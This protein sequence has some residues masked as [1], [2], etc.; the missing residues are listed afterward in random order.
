M[1]TV[2]I[3]NKSSHDYSKAEYFGKI[4]YLFVG[5]MCV[6]SVNDLDRQFQ[7]RLK[8]STDKDYLVLTSLTVMNSLACVILALKHKKLNLL[9]YK[10]GNY[11]ERNLHFKEL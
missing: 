4:I 9:I 6:Y 8:D 11:I 1:P 3:V 5:A 10:N 2:Y 7:D